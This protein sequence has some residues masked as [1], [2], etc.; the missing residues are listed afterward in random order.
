M[1][2]DVLWRNKTA[3][4][5]E[6][7]NATMRAR[8][9]LDLACGTGDMALAVYRHVPAATIV[10]VD[11]ALEMLRLFRQKSKTAQRI[12]I[13]A[14]ADELPFRHGVFQFI[15]CAFGVRNFISLEK[16]I[17]Q[18]YALLVP[19]GRLVTL[20]FF[21][22][23]NGFTRIFFK[24]Y[25]S[26]A[27]M[28]IGFVLNRKLAPYHYLCRSIVRFHTAAE[29]GALLQ[30]CDYRVVTVKPLFVGLACLIVAEK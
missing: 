30:K 10:A 18:L 2:L 13:V 7:T 5:M 6:K 21:R 26:T 20:E 29:Y 1:G 8:T 25:S 11:P 24:L 3:R 22:P 27:L 23:D 19:G 9:C 16:N 14:G 28:I 17:R 4:L 12:H 15:T